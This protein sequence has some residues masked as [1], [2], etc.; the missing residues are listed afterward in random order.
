MS[1]FHPLW[2]MWRQAYGSLTEAVCEVLRYLS[3]RWK[4]II[5]C[6]LCVIKRVYLWVCVSECNASK[7]KLINQL[8]REM[9]S[10]VSQGGTSVLLI[11]HNTEKLNPNIS[12]GWFISQPLVSSVNYAFMHHL[13]LSQPDCSTSL[14]EACE[15]EE[16]RCESERNWGELGRWRL[17]GRQGMVNFPLVYKITRLLWM[18][19]GLLMWF[20]HNKLYTVTCNKHESSNE[21]MYT[22][23]VLW[24]FH[25]YIHMYIFE[26]QWIPI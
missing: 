22:K 20:I 18:C 3:E 4:G 6:F 5:F 10:D 24:S 19:S 7:L 9:M 15:P 14:S 25:S 11:L 23:H 1:A 13:P 12:D 21:H 26:T 8:S 16:Q 17:A 2:P